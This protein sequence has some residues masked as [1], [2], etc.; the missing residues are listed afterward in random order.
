[1]AEQSNKVEDTTDTEG[2][3]TMLQKEEDFQTPKK[4]TKANPEHGETDMAKESYKVKDTTDT[5][6]MKSLINM[7]ISQIQNQMQPVQDNNA[8]SKR[9]QQIIKNIKVFMDEKF[10]NMQENP[11]T[12]YIFQDMSK[13]DFGK[14]VKYPAV[15]RKVH[16]WASKPKSNQKQNVARKFLC[17]G[18]ENKSCKAIR[19]QYYCEGTCR[20]PN[21]DDNKCCRNG[22]GKKLVVFYEGIHQCKNRLHK[23]TSIEDVEWRLA[24]NFPNHTIKTAYTELPEDLN[25]NVIFILPLK[26]EEEIALSEQVKCGR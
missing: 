6:S 1:M 10:E 5:E 15:N 9:S 13:I 2:I 4:T 14:G 21:L 20:K 24:D 3:Q 25:E 26:P 7:R 19:W 12:M 11:N 16:K 18:L 8:R 23:I 17:D 22:T